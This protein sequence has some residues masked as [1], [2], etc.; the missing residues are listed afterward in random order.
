MLAVALAYVLYKR[1]ISFDFG[2]GSAY[3]IAY[4]CALT[5]SFLLNRNWSF[6][7]TGR[8][9]STSIRFFVIHITS[10]LCSILVQQ[11]TVHMIPPQNKGYE[12]AF[13]SAIAVS[14]AINFVGSKFY[15]YR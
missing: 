10:Y 4:G 3:V 12:I 2:S 6:Q 11:L 15:I 13:F 14:T 1:L 8:Y 5:L 9:L 7:H